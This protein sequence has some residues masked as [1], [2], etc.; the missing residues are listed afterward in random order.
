MACSLTII[1][2]ASSVSFSFFASAFVLGGADLPLSEI[3]FQDIVGRAERGVYRTP[4]RTSSS[5]TRS[6]RRIA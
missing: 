2:R 1:S 5:S 3:P 4:R 6:S